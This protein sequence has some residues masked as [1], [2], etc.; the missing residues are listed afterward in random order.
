METIKLSLEF[1]NPEKCRFFKNFG[2]Y[3]TDIFY[4]I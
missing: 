4:L 3:T 2:C 1:L